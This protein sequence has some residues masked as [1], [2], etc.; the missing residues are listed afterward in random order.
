MAM[1]Q[2]MSCQTQWTLKPTVFFSYSRLPVVG[3]TVPQKRN[4]SWGGWCLRKRPK[5]CPKIEKP[6]ALTNIDASTGRLLKALGFLIFLGVSGSDYLCFPKMS[7]KRWMKGNLNRNFG[8]KWAN[9]AT[10]TDFPKFTRKATSYWHPA[11]GLCG[12]E[13]GIIEKS[14]SLMVARGDLGAV[15][16][17]GLW[18][19]GSSD[20]DR[21]LW[22]LVKTG[23]T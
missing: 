9:W 10:V 3:Y 12:S 21:G 17:V 19:L 22:G 13:D 8:S 6:Q 1:G 7:R 11:L 4:D 23:R 20:A 14:Q 2:N 16:T 5:I 15:G 18:T